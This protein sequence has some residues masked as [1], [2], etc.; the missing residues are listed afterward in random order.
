MNATLVTLRGKVLKGFPIGASVVHEIDLDNIVGPDPATWDTIRF[1]ICDNDGS[2]YFTVQKADMTVT[3]SGTG[4]WSLVLL[5]PQTEAQS[6]L[7][8]VGTGTRKWQLDFATSG[9]YQDVAVEGTV[10]VWTPATPLP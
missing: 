1:S 2:A 6:R 3:P 4:P 9:G 10:P 7:V 8:D 5:I